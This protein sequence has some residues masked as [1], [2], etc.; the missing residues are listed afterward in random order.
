MKVPRSIVLTVL[1]FVIILF[2]CLFVVAVCGAQVGEK[3]EI[4]LRNLETGNLRTAGLGGLKI[5]EPGLILGEKKE[6]SPIEALVAKLTFL[7]VCVFLATLW[8]FAPVSSSH[9]DDR[10]RRTRKDE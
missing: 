3:T 8:W 1:S 6:L 9:T 2:I 10:E 7:A 4:E 5:F